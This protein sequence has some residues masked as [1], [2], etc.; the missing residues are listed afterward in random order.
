MLEKI[1]GIQKSTRKRVRLPWHQSV[2]L[3]RQREITDFTWTQG[4]TSAFKVKNT[5][6][7]AVESL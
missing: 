1:E 7:W 6:H 2:G 4:R 5:F 3:A